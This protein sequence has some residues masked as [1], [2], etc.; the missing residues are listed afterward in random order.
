[1]TKYL[2]SLT[3]LLNHKAMEKH[4][5]EK[6]GQDE[7]V[8]LA[9]IDV[10]HFLEVNQIL[11]SEAGD[12]VLRQLAAVLKEE[13]GA[14]AYRVSG[15]EFA[16]VLE[17]ATLEQAFLQMERFRAKIEASADVFQLPQEHRIT[18]TVGVAQYPRDGKTES[19]LRRAASAALVSAK[20]IGRNQVALPPNEEMVM[21]S[22]Y[23]PST[24][25]RRLKSLA[26]QLNKKESALLRE[27]L[28]DLLRK[29]DRSE[30][31]RK[32]KHPGHS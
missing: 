11:G 26:E 12:Q 1:M 22:C 18:V 3:G 30:V 32:S 21:K 17:G 10:D 9:M 2:D 31:A 24:N 4:V 23:Y 28:D 29:Y 7:Q 20:E 14:E 13:P 5:Q 25:V 8:A 16:L 15:D 6:I 19:A 27:A